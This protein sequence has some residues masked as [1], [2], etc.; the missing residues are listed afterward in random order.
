M[1]TFMK[2]NV[3]KNAKI[4]FIKKLHICEEKPKANTLRDKDFFLVTTLNKF[5]R[6][7]H[8]V[9]SYTETPSF[10]PLEANLIR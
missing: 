9:G 1:K 2:N 10:F 7:I 5:L 8:L 3:V 4:C 6:T